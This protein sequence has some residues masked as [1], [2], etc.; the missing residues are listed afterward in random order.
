MDLILGKFSRYITY[1]GNALI[2]WKVLSYIFNFFEPSKML[3]LMAL[4]VFLITWTSL[5][6]FT[7]YYIRKEESIYNGRK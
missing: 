4:I 3:D 1:I 2:V 5:N 7:I 6:C